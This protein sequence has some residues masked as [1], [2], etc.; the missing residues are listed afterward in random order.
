M[1]FFV[2]GNCRNKIKETY[3]AVHKRLTFIIILNYTGMFKSH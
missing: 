1:K 2:Y 3:Q